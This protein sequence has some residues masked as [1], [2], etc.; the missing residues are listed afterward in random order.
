MPLESIE[1]SYPMNPALPDGGISRSESVY[2][3]LL[4]WI[5]EG[6]IPLDGK[7]PTEN[8]LTQHFQVSRPVVRTAI[9]KLREKGLVRSVQGSGTVVIHE[10]APPA[11][12]SMQLLQGSSVRD[13][14]RCFEFRLLI[15]SEAAYLAAL[16]HSPASLERISECVY[17]PTHTFPTKSQQPLEAFDFHHFVVLAADN[18]FLEH[19]I[20]TI[21]SQRGFQVYLRL[22]SATK[23]SD[24]VAHR[25]RINGEHR[26]ILRLIERRQAEDAREYMRYHIQSAYE[27]MINKIPVTDED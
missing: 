1:S 16:R 13:L 15:E 5:E 21:V 23:A 20:Q 3:S 18:P 19:S 4:S 27:Y 11:V 10:P 12:N 2:R 24:P 8:E 7:L 17:P 14:Q 26:E 6:R 22:C 9:A 25:T